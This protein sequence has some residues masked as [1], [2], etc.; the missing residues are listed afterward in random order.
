MNNFSVIYKILKHLERM[1]DFETPD[2]SLITPE[3][4]GISENRYNALLVML[5]KNGYVEGAVVKKYT[6]EE[7]YRVVNIDGMHITLKGLEYLF[8]NSLMRKISQ[9]MLGVVDVVSKLK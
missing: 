4:L 1:L 2:M 6:D 9:G 5:V 7:V 3:A 8:E